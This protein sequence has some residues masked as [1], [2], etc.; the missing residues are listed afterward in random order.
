[1]ELGVRSHEA[2]GKLAPRGVVGAIEVEALLEHPLLHAAVGVLHISSK[3]FVFL[4]Q[5]VNLSVSGFD[6]PIE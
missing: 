6:G 4:L 2:V 3:L 1:L 5:V